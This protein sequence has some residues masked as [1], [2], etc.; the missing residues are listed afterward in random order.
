MQVQKRRIYDITNVLEGI[1]LIEKKSKNNIQWKGN[2]PAVADETQAEYAALKE[3]VAQMQVA[4]LFLLLELP[5]RFIFFLLPLLACSSFQLTASWAGGFAA[6]G[7]SHSHNAEQCGPHDRAYGQ[8]VLPHCDSD[9][10]A[11]CF[12]LQ[13]SSSTACCKLR[14]DIMLLMLHTPPVAGILSQRPQLQCPCTESSRSRRYP[15]PVRSRM[16]VTNEDVVKLR[17]FGEDT[18][19]AVTAPYGTTLV[20]PDPDEG[21]EQGGERRYRRAS[22]P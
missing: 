18:V 7:G 3:E 14:V 15:F 9:L 5:Y 13:L 12:A 21:L 4:H 11:S 19:F 10:Q 20:V 17:S 1:G 8:Q 22:L 2:G 16:Y 6:A